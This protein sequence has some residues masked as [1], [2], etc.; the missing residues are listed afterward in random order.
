MHLFAQAESIREQ[1]LPGIDGFLG[2]RGSLMMD[3]VVTAMGLVLLALG[4]SWY[5]VR[6]RRQYTGHKRIQVALGLLLLVTIICFEFDIQ[7]LSKWKLRAAASP[8]F[9][10]EHHW[11]CPVGISLLVHL[12]FAVPTLILWVLVIVQALRRFPSPP[13]P[14]PHSRWHVRWARIGAAGMVMTSITG[15]IFY[16]LAFASK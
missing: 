12:C 4:L 6:F 5:L 16:A 14:G 15:W 9:N 1:S 11:R 13:H 7:Y 3:V 2:T 10:V 8:Y